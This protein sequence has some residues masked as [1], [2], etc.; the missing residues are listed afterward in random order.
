MKFWN[1]N[2]EEVVEV[3]Q[4]TDTSNFAFHGLFPYTGQDLEPNVVSSD[5]TELQM[6]LELATKRADDLAAKVEELVECLAAHNAKLADVKTLIET[7]A[8][9]VDIETI[10]TLARVTV[11]LGIAEP[12]A[13]E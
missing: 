9:D 3:E 4:G 11:L 6:E 8:A 12:P 5:V 1:K 7:E 10:D 13:A 2:T